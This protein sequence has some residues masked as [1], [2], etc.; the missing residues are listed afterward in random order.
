M[1]PFS[2]RL[3]QLM[4]QIFNFFSVRDL[5][6]LALLVELLTRGVE[7]T[8]DILADAFDSAFDVFGVLNKLY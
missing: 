5:L 8:A 2:K 7:H 4:P 6:D 1:C 3:T